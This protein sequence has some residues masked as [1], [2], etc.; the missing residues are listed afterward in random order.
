MA[1]GDDLRKAAT[2]AAMIEE[3]ARLMLYIKQ[4][5]GEVTHLSPEWVKK[6]EPIKDFL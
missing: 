5:G 3:T 6:L 4:F 1:V 2:R